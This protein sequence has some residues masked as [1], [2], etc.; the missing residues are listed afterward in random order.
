MWDGEG[1]VMPVASDKRSCPKTWLLWGF[2]ALGFCALPNTITY[3]ITLCNAI[4]GST[5]GGEKWSFKAVAAQ[6]PFAVFQGPEV[7]LAL[8]SSSH[9]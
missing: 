1:W 5:F 8:L 3:C 6:S 9:T 7:M 2:Y 4:Q